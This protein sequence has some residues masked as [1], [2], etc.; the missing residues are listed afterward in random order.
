VNQNILFIL[1]ITQTIQRLDDNYRVQQE[2]LKRELRAVKVTVNMVCPVYTN[3]LLFQNKLRKATQADD[4]EDS[5]E[6]DTEERCRSAES[7][8]RET[9]LELAS[10]KLQLV[11]SQCQVQELDHK[12]TEIMHEPTHKGWSQWFGRKNT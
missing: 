8:L 4:G 7:K 10:T 11:E 12:L 3:S 1:F 6:D 2:D 9:E 5:V